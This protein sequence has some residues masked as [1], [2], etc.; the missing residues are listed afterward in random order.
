MKGSQCKNYHFNAHQGRM[1]GDSQTACIWHATNGDIQAINTVSPN[2]HINLHTVQKVEGK[3]K[4][5][6]RNHAK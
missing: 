5:V 4:M 6:E 1:K 2:V 3:E